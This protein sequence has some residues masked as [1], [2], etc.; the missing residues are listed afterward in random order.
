MSE[1]VLV[2]DRPSAG[3]VKHEDLALLHEVALRTPGEL[4]ASRCASNVEPVEVPAHLPVPWT[5]LRAPFLPCCAPGCA[6]KS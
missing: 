6:M 4:R 3:P 5:I 1:P 2:N